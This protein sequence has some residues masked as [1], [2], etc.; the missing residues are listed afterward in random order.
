MAGRIPNVS[1]RIVPKS[2]TLPETG[3]CFDTTTVVQKRRSNDKVDDSAH[4]S[5]F[6]LS[7]PSKPRTTD[8]FLRKGQGTGGS[9][10]VEK[11]IKADKLETMSPRSRHQQPAA[12]RERSNPP[13]TSFRRFYERGDLPIQIDHGGV[14][15]MVAWKVDITKLDFHHYLPIFFDGLRE[16]E[17]PYAF[18]SEQGIKDMLINASNKVL[19]VIPQLIIPIK[20]A[21]N[22]RN[23]GII[24][25][26]LHI[27]QLMVT[28][29]S[30]AQPGSGPG[31]IG[32]ALVPYYR[33]ILPV[34]NIFIRKNG[35]FP[36]RFKER[37]CLT[38]LLCRQH[39]RCDRL[40]PTETTESG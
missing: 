39:W 35:T 22:T 24:V 40:R 19:P 38:V 34:L 18:L 13:D 30:A 23:A 6:S 8:S 27:L 21:L 33:Q 15:N 29:E 31:L 2:I 1:T 17:E 5:A 20:N 11:T 36:V 12:F 10:D 37:P 3:S 16:V 32:Q 7:K 4:I 28:C 9:I 14:R 25:K 26:T